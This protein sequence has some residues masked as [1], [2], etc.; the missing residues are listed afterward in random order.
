MMLIRAMIAGL[1][2]HVYPCSS[3][4]V[5]F[6][7][8]RINFIALVPLQLEHFLNSKK[9]ISC[10]QSIKHVLIGGAPISPHLNT[11]L[12]NE[13]ITVEH[14]Y[15]MTETIS[16][17]A[18]KKTGLLGVDYYTTLKDISVSSH[19]ESLCIDYPEIKN[20]IIQTNDRVELIDETSFRWLGRL[21][22]VINSGGIKMS[23][24]LIENKIST[25]ISCPFI[26][27]GIPDELLG[28][29][30]VIIIKDEE[31]IEKHLSKNLLAPYVEKYELPKA[32]CVVKE[33]ARTKNNKIDRPLTIKEA[34]KR[35][36]KKLL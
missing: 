31:S 30:V 20:E 1:T 32:Y 11:K 9:G 6:I 17:I 2:L 26:I 35:G 16:H 4:A 14:S 34:T 27:A 29:K 36:W 28:E 3:R 21:D 24:E 8:E 22:H 10:L 25:G 12:I 19:K 7:N 15:G 18:L 33:L 13:K 23:P 5:D